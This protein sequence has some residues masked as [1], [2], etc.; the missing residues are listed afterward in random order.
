V[1]IA[2]S[3][4]DLK[5]K[6]VRYKL[7]IETLAYST[8]STEKPSVGCTI[9][10]V[11]DKVQVH[12]LL[13]VRHVLY[14]YFNYYYYIEMIINLLFEVNFTDRCIASS[15]LYILTVQSVTNNHCFYRVLSFTL[16]AK[17]QNLLKPIRYYVINS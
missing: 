2:C 3:D 16:A 14:M 15:Y 13:K 11:T 7:L 1:Y 10:T 8:L 4:P 17:K 9:I 6:I 12:L 5:E